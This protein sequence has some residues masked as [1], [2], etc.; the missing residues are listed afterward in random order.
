MRHNFYYDT[1]G[2]EIS[3]AGKSLDEWQ[4]MGQDQG[5]MIADPLFVN[6]ENFDFRLRA[7]SPA[8]KGGFQQIDMSTVGP[9]VPTGADSW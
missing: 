6:A 9:R 2:G 8:L 4:A 3:F 7:E 5:S 1:R